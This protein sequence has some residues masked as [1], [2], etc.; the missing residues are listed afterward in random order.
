DTETNHTV[1]GNSAA[2]DP[3]T[4]LAAEAIPGG[5]I[6]T[7]VKPADLDIGEYWIYEDDVNSI[8]ADPAFKIPA[9]TESWT[10][11]GLDSGET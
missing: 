3:V 4:S 2:P 8:P 1:V 10:R 9:P 5:A 11:V 7:W 6:L